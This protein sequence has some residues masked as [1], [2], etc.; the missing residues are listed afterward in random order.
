MPVSTEGEGGSQ[1]EDTSDSDAGDLMIDVTG[2]KKRPHLELDDD[3]YALVEENTGARFQ[4][5]AMKG[6]PLE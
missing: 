1:S 5:C 4:V 6:F 2:T 3:D